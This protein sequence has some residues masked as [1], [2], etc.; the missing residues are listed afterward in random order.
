MMGSYRVSSGLLAAAFVLAACSGGGPSVAPA[1]GTRP[2]GPPSQESNVQPAIAKIQHVVLIIQENRSFDDLFSTFPGADGATSGK[3]HNGTV[4]PL[5][6]QPLAALDINHTYPTYLADYDNGNMDGFDLSKMGNGGRA[7][8]YPYQYVD[9][10]DI[11]PY[12]TLAKDYV[13]A[14]HTFQTQGSGSFTA[15][16]DLIAGG[17]IIDSSHS[18]VD[19]PSS[20]WSWGCDA[21]PSTVT[22]LITTGGQYQFDQGPF[23]CLTYPTGTLRDLLDKAKMSWKYYSPPHK[24]NAPGALWNA[25]DAIPAV[26]YGPEWTTNVSVP[27]TNIFNDITGGQLAAVSW[28]IPDQV[29]SDHP[30]T[31]KSQYDGPSWVASVVN[32]IGTSSYWKTT[33]IVILWDDWGGFYDHVSPAFI[34]HAG[35][36][37]FR[38]PMLVVSPYV[39]PGTIAHTQYE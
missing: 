12:W 3:M 33:T 15:H 2:G 4:V 34:D 22:S 26:R 9:P 21:K 37:G 24:G 5:K 8:K 18:I 36:L 39:K 25:F 35:G 20:S 28:V 30:Q 11:Q 7:G 31:L 1:V 19:D 6:E 16:Q 14:D 23:P 29:D 32:A 13:L 17:T 38:V 10:N 27:E